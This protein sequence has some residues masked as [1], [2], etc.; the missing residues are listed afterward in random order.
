MSL[1][2]AQRLLFSSSLGE[3]TPVPVRVILAGLILVAAGACGATYRLMG[4][5]S[6]IYPD[7]FNRAFLD[8]VLAWD[9]RKKPWMD[10]LHPTKRKAFRAI[11]LAFGAE[12]IPLP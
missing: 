5:V 3:P 7:R 2:Y 1:I 10:R 6:V 8:S 11:A 12:R 4:K 9:L